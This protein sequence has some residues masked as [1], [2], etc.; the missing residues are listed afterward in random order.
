MLNLQVKYA[1][2]YNIEWE[3]IIIMVHID[4]AN[5]MDEMNNG[6]DITDS[7][8]A[9]AD[10]KQWAQLLTMFGGSKSYTLGTTIT[11]GSFGK[12]R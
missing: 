8:N 10:T 9:E 5:S 2:I 12:S 6:N 4:T 11:L 1:K 3:I 7:Q